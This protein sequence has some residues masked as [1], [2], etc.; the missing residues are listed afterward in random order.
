ARR[1]ARAFARRWHRFRRRI[2][3]AQFYDAYSALMNEAFSGTL[4]R[5]AEGTGI[6][7]TGHEILPHV[8]YWSLNGGFTTID[9]RV[10]LAV[11]FFG[12]D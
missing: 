2:G 9:P 6:V 5:W 3:C 1:H 11:D 4:R 7:L 12:I 10:A 8:S